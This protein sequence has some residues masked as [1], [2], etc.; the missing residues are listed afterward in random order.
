[1]FRLPPLNGNKSL[2]CALGVLLVDN[3]FPLLPPAWQPVL[4]PVGEV[5]KVVCGGALVPA[6]GHKL[7][8]AQDGLK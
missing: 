8:K 2:L 5:V 6:L 7:L 1:M 3:V 4:V